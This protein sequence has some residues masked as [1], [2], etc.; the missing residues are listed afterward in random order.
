MGINKKKLAE[1]VDFLISRDLN[2][3][4]MTDTKV[5]RRVKNIWGNADKVSRENY[6]FVKRQFENIG[7]DNAVQEIDDLI[8]K[9][10]KT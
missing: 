2:S 9:I 8:Q 6:D 3:R 10:A 5:Y 7:L 1:F 4:D